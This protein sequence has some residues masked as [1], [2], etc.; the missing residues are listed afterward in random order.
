VF[1][2]DDCGLVLLTLVLLQN[3]R[4]QVLELFSQDLSYL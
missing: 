2:S 1:L 4:M 3:L